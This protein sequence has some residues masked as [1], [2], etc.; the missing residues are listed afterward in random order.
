MKET[1]GCGN[2]T[3]SAKPLKY[4]P[5]DKYLSYRRKIKAEEYKKRGWL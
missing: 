1:C 3:L 5:N 2:R 4:T